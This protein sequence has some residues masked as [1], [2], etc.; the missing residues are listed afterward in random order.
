MINPHFLTI[1]S[2]IIGPANMVR[3]GKR[4]GTVFSENDAERIKKDS[5]AG[6][7]DHTKHFAV[8]PK[9][10]NPQANLEECKRRHL[11]QI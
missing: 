2:E 7:E 8:L 11:H 1:S 6:K 9:E 3:Y 5:Q 10:K 4:K